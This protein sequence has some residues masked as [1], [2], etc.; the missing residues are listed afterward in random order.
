MAHKLTLD[1]LKTE[2]A[3]GAV[4]GL[5][6]IA[7]LVVA[8]SPL[9]EAYFYWLKSEHLF[10]AGPLQLELSVSE[11][12]KEGL[13]AVFFLVVGLEIKYEI[14]KGELSDPKKLVTPIVAALGG[15][16]APAGLY[17]LVSGVLGGPHDGWPIPLA[18]DIAFA[19]AV[20]AL[21]GKGLPSSLRVFLLT[22]AIV[23]DLGAIALIA[24]LF[25]T[26]VDWMLVGAA[27]LLLL[28]G[29]VM[30]LRR[31]IAPV[32]VL[33]FALV[34][35]LSVK[36]GLST[37]LA[38]VAF[39]AIVPV[40]PRADDKQS[41]LKEAMHDLHPYVAYLVLPLF[42]FAKAGVS[43]AGLS[44]DQMFAPLVLGVAAGLFIGKQIGVMGAAWLVSA[45]KLGARPSGA[46]WLQIYGVSL[47]CGVGFTM[48]LFIGALAFPGA[49]DSPEQVEVKLGV[50]LGSVLSATLGGIVLSVASNRKRASRAS[51]KPITES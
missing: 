11:W 33:G 47:L 12:I 21:V 8:N 42:A 26:G 2:A 31:I 43:F 41:P 3:S 38:A 27:S 16:L 35:W 17:L 14:L 34:W 15:M 45:L 40:S 39:A 25:S 9:S 46:S 29:S 50:I 24:V 20:F 28:V 23:D 19:L 32:W 13:M 18:T 44:I 10:Q 30:S 49:V 7:A 36:A 22:L 1:F 51:S 48:S 37:S 6:A 4:L 5:A